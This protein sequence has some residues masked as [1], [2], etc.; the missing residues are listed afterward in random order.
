MKLKLATRSL[1]LPRA[2]AGRAAR[3]S[4]LFL[5]TNKREETKIS[6]TSLSITELLK[7]PRSSQSA[8][9]GEQVLHTH[10][11]WGT[12]FSPSS[13]PCPLLILGVLCSPCRF[14]AWSC[15]PFPSSQAFPTWI[16]F[17]IRRL[18][19]PYCPGKVK[20]PPETQP[21]LAPCWQMLLLRSGTQLPVHLSP[22]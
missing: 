16:Y 20:D 4:L 3:T 1:S 8:A 19:F 15:M 5:T 14:S 18:F 2:P 17:L 11:W 9:E 12:R 7:G 22:L 6:P 10:H 21:P 13:G